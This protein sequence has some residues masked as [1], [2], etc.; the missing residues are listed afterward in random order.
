MNS[1]VEERNELFD[2][3]FK[4]KIRDLDKIL[5]FCKKLSDETGIQVCTNNGHL[6]EYLPQV[7][8]SVVKK[9]EV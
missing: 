2:E 5:K 7:Y 4:P 8:N 1:L 6:Y 9:Y 3:S